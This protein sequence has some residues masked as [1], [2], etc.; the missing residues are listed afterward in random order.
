MVKAIRKGQ[1]EMYPIRAFYEAGSREWVDDRESTH[2][3]S[4]LYSVYMELNDPPR[5]VQSGRESV[6]SHYDVRI[7]ESSADLVALCKQAMRP[8]AFDNLLHSVLEFGQ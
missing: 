7:F 3:V 8:R 6:N 2:E 4:V 1:K 5:D